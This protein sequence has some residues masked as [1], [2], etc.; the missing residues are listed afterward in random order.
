MSPSTSR[1]GPGPCRR[2]KAAPVLSMHEMRPEAEDANPDQID[3]ND[4]MDEAGE[5]EHE[6][7]GNEGDAG[8]QHFKTEVHGCHSILAERWAMLAKSFAHRALGH[9]GAKEWF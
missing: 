8:G 2:R 5:E 1:A 6:Q 9:K 3:A 7:S 4:D